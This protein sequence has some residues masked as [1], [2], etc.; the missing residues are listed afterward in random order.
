MSK[1]GE[2]LI[3]ARGKL[4]QRE[5]AK[6]I[7]ISH[8][9]L[10]KIENGK[11]PRTGKDIKPTPE[12]LKLISKAYQCDYEE[13]MIKAGYIDEN[14]TS[15]SEGPKLTEHQRKIYEWAKSH[16]GLFFDSKPEDVEE[17][18]EEFEVVYELFKKRKER[19]KK[20]KK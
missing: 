2:Y 3:K 7:G 12:T 9:Y 19:E 4:S 18:I 6:R 10:G 11:D 1:L 13:L 16:D 14:E 15:N 8:T 20:Q 5:A 17:L